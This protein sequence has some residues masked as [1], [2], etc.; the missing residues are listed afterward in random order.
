MKAQRT[1]DVTIEIAFPGN[2]TSL[3]TQLS[4]V[5][6]KRLMQ[7]GAFRNLVKLLERSAPETNGGMPRVL[8]VHRS[9]ET[10]R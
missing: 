5:P 7:M 2:G 10:E 3:K 4:S 9:A 8:A 6:R 1:Y